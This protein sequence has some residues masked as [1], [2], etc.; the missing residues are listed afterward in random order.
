MTKALTFTLKRSLIRR[1]LLSAGLVMALG[2][3][4][5]ALSLADPPDLE[6]PDTCVECHEE[7][8]DAWR[9]SPHGTTSAPDQLPEATCESCHG[10]YLEDHPDQGYMQL[11]IDSSVCEDCHTSTFEQWE[12]TQHQQAG[13]QCISCHLS[14]SQE[15][16][17]TDEALC[18][19]CHEAEIDDI[20]HMAHTTS[21]VPCV[22]CHVSVTIPQGVAVASTGP[23]SGPIAGPSH[24]FADVSAMSC[25]ECHRDNVREEPSSFTD[26]DWLVKSRLVA[27]A[28]RVPELAS[29]LEATQQANK[30]L[31]TWLPVSLGLGLGIGGMLG[32]VAVLLLAHASRREAE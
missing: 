17:L 28:E 18:S 9:N 31:Q 27:Q 20:F 12:H 1:L 30:S 4:F 7:E 13:V 16:R 14:H 23:S 5:P 26:V 15:F 22:D 21:E 10:A 8:T 24:D 2:L 11:T 3:L 29:E 32:I 19:S 6:D 25:I